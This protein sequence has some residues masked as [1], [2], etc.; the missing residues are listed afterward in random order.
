[1]RNPARLSRAIALACG[2]AAVSAFGSLPPPAPPVLRIAAPEPAPID[3]G[4][5][6]AGFYRDRDFV[7]LWVQGRSLRPDAAGLRRRLDDTAGSTRELDAALAAARGGDR[8]AL[9]RADLLLTRAFVDHVAELRRP[10][11]VNSLRYIDPGLAPE[12]LDVRALLDELAVAPSLTRALTE[13]ERVNPVADGLRLGL[14]DY[15]ARWSRLP[16]LSVAAGPAL[17]TGA[18]GARV[19][20]LRRRLGLQAGGFDPALAARLGEFQQAHGLPA[21][22]AADAATI[23]ALNAGADHY[24][25]LILA[26][27]ERARAIPART[28][29]YILVDA[30]A[31]RLWLVED[32][33]LAGTMKV[34]VGK[35]DMQTPAMA[36]LIRYIVLNPYWILPPDLIR[37]RARNVL[38]RGPRA[39]AAENLQILS[40]WTPRAQTLTPRQVDWG[41]LASGRRWVALR[42]RPGPRNMMGAVKFMMPNDLGV[43]LHDTPLREFFAR[44]D[45]RISSGCVRLED[46]ARL[47][48][49]LFHDVPPRPSG[50]AEQRVDLPEP[51]PVY[52]AYFTAVPSRG[53]I[54]F[55]PDRYGRDRSL[56]AAMA[57]PSGRTS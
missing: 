39:I 52:I 19:E 13:A 57:A 20:A 33:R 6:I 48:R 26:N 7:P 27:L 30:A 34:I 36:G 49:W 17:A 44:D 15:R 55:Q 4:E 23:A 41:A 25:R 42:Q 8:P 56:L 21:S 24:E 11:A 54:V 31:A 46:A 37:K 43:Y 14:A 2:L 53:R 3:V 50:A 10:P 1:M 45:R 35:Q 51:V 16:Q 29:R 32:G 18:A 5:E 22:G 9:A 28:G 47:A 38:R 40:D 12:P